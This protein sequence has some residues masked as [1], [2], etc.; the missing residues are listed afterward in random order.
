MAA[1]NST[2]DHLLSVTQQHQFCNHFSP[3]PNL[4]FKDNIA[5][6]MG[7]PCTNSDDNNSDD[8]NDDDKEDDFSLLHH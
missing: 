5:N 7:S 4:D 8:N 6:W 2:Y 3:S 1:P